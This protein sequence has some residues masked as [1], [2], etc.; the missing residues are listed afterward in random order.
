M[1]SREIDTLGRLHTDAID[2]MNGYGEALKD[3]DG[4]SLFIL[5]QQMHT[6]H[7]EA[8]AELSDELRGLGAKAESTGSLM[9]IVHESIMKLRSLVGGLD[10]SVLP[11][12]I[13]GEKRTLDQYDSALK[14]GGLQPSSMTVVARQ[15]DKLAGAIAAMQSASREKD[16]DH[17]SAAGSR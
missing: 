7:R 5:F 3:S 4:R 16:K 15:R 13:D 6:F 11:G 12:L 14:D 8:A 10:A 9:S 1:G 17:A 2:A